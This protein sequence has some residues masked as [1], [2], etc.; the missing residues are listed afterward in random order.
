MKTSI[1]AI[2]G[3]N[4]NQ[5]QRNAP[6]VDAAA[7]PDTAAYELLLNAKISADREIQRLAARVAQLSDELAAIDEH[8]RR[9]LAQDLHD[10]TGASLTAARLA[11]ARVETW[12]PSDAPAPC[13]EALDTA[14]QSLD[15]ACEAS[16]RVV[17][18]LHAPQLDGGVVW[19]LSCWVERFEAA[20]SIPVLLEFPDDP[21]LSE[22]SETFSLAMFRVAQEALNN[23]AKH[24]KASR[25]SVRLALDARGISLTV[26]D[27]GVG[28]TAAAR[29]KAG[30]FG[31]SG[32]R[33][34]CDALGGSLRLVSQASGTS[35]RARFPWPGATPVLA[36][37]TPANARALL[38][39]LNS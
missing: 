30:R 7:A 39:A 23:V 22:L 16:Q 6:R 19:A 4:G 28:L 29:R 33:A 1:V 12:L 11:I 10:D 38:R 37:V 18:G 32:M 27:N 35:V 15:A 34:R 26:E 8:V 14:R 2:P 13:A 5:A 9:A 25:V 17:E 20:T 36:S 31:L 21:R 3:A 24:A